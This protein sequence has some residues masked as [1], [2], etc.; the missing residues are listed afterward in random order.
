MTMDEATW[1]THVEPSANW[2]PGQRRRRRKSVRHS[3]NAAVGLLRS[4]MSRDE[5]D[6]DDLAY[7]ADALDATELL[8]VGVANLRAQ[9]VAWSSIGEALGVD[10]VSAFQRF[11]RRAKAYLAEHPDLVGE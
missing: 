7:L 9:G 8:T 1:S 6:V 4:N 11:D 3:L 10:R 5:F 2:R